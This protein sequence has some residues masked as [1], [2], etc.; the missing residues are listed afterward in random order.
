MSDS[1][2][3][4]LAVRMRGAR[5]ASG[6]VD[7]WFGDAWLAEKYDWLVSGRNS[8]DVVIRSGE[9]V[10]LIDLRC[11]VSL[12]VTLWI[13]KWSDKAARLVDRLKTVAPWFLQVLIGDGSERQLI[14]FAWT[15]RHGDMTLSEAMAGGLAA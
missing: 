12:G 14:G 4:L 11:F 9:N 3:T 15:P 1:L 5:P 6:F 2:Q 8:A 10:D 13:D 7:V